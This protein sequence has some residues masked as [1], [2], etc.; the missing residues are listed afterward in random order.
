M[1]IEMRNSGYADIVYLMVFA[2]AMA[3]FAGVISSEAFF[4]SIGADSVSWTTFGLIFGTIITF[5]VAR[6]SWGAFRRRSLELN[7]DTKEN[8]ILFQDR[9]PWPT[10]SHSV[11][12]KKLDLEVFQFEEDIYSATLSLKIRNS[13]RIGKG[14]LSFRSEYR[15]EDAKPPWRRALAVLLLLP[16]I[17]VGVA[18]YMPDSDNII[19]G[20]PWVMLSMLAV[21]TAIALAL[22]AF[23][24]T[25]VQKVDGAIEF[26]WMRYREAVLNASAENFAL[27]IQWLV[28]NH[29]RPNFR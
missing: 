5:H 12:L 17:S 28:R 7:I 16:L 6:F 20:A 29:N 15:N 2:L 18:P 21:A 9:A 14:G 11:P 10:R 8:T 1:N 27:G 3:G 25:N 24:M 19:E 22:Y 23:V 13:L 4:E 26:A